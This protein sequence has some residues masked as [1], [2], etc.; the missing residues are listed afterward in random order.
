MAAKDITADRARELLH[1]DPE[2][3]V[4]TRRVASGKTHVGDV[5]GS[6]NA[7]GYMM[8]GVDGSRYLAHRLAWLYTYGEWP[9]Q[10]IDHIDQDKANN[11]IANL[12]DVSRSANN[13]NRSAA[14]S[15]SGT[16]IAN[17]CPVT[18]GRR[19]YRVRLKL[20]GVI[21]YHKHFYTIEEAIAARDE[22]RAK[23]HPFAPTHTKPHAQ[24]AP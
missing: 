23:F 5:T 1:Y 15:N 2:T 21:V 12:R 4:F 16:G 11:R 7:L 13:Q 20:N 9:K 8:V 22:A 6:K 19:P 14:L 10:D 18:A 17:V 24:S 3:G